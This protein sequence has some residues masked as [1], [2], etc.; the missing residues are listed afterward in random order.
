MCETSHGWLKSQKT[1]ISRDTNRV[2]VLE[3]SI[4]LG[5]KFSP[6]LV[7]RFSIIPIK[8][9]TDFLNGKTCWVTGKSRK[10]RIAYT[11]WKKGKDWRTPLSILPQESRQGD[12]AG[13]ATNTGA[14]THTAHVLQTRHQCSSTVQRKSFPKMVLGQ[15]TSV[16]PPSLTHPWLHQ[17]RLKIQT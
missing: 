5:Q 16:S 8:I 13:M 14:G 6:K 11:V 9:C 1:K 4:T 10:T 12:R 7:C 2:H 17:D 15:H 3:N